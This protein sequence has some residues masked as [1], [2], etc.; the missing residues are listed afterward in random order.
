MGKNNAK[1]L[2][3]A[4]INL[5]LNLCA[6]GVI[7][8]M[9]CPFRNLRPAHP[10]RLLSLEPLSHPRLPEWPLTQL[11]G[12]S[13]SCFCNASLGELLGIPSALSAL[14]NC[15]TDEGLTRALASIQSAIP[16]SSLF[17]ERPPRVAPGAARNPSWGSA[18]CKRP[19]GPSLQDTS[20]QTLRPENQMVAA[21][22]PKKVSRKSVSTRP[23]PSLGE[24]KEGAEARPSSG[25]LLAKTMELEEGVEPGSRLTVH[26]LK[27]RLG[28]QVVIGLSGELGGVLPSYGSLAA[29]WKRQALAPPLR[30][31]PPF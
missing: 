16:S 31:T 24:A 29:K 1:D 15:L 9:T 3:K 11:H 12:A 27:S 17:S 2:L 20:Q 18:G 8:T 23:E 14:S 28:L 5:L 25:S 10:T 6:W 7:S 26:W 13:H 22:F 19:G 21:T 4:R 30:Q